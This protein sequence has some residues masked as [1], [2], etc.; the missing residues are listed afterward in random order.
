MQLDHSFPHHHLIHQR[1]GARRSFLPLHPASY[2]CVGQTPAC[3]S[4]DEAMSKA[5]VGEQ[6]GRMHLLP[7]P[8]KSG[9]DHMAFVQSELRG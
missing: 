3:H 7:S 9:E 2:R 5:T 4:I 6:G 1:P 8:E